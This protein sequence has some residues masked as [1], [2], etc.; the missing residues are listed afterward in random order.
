MVSLRFKIIFTAFLLALPT[1]PVFAE[2]EKLSE[3]K[4]GAISQYCETTRQTLK[5]IQKSD[6]K[7]RTSL[8]PTFERLQTKF[9]TPLNVSLV[10]QNF[11]VPEFIAAQAEFANLKSSFNKNFTSYSLSLDELISTDCKNNP[12]SFYEKLKVVR[13]KR[14]TLYYDIISIKE[15]LEDYKGHVLNLK[16]SL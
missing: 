8:G 2:E 6:T 16:E 1:V 15:I 3:E 11:S 10:N 14:E 4:L 5:S 9:I 12:E 7:V 13:A